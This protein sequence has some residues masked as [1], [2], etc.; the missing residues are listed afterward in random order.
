M[1]NY[2]LFLVLFLIILSGCDQDSPN[3]P[4]STIPVLSEISAPDLIYLLAQSTITI[5][6]KVHDPQGVIDIQ[7]VT[8]DINPDGNSAAARSLKMVDNGSQ[9]DIIPRDGRFTI[10][11]KADTVFTQGG[12]YSLTFQATDQSGNESETVTHQIKAY[13]EDENIPPMVTLNEIPLSI[14]IDDTVYYNISVKV[15]DF[16]GQDD[17]DKVMVHAYS[18]TSAEPVFTGELKDDGVDADETAGDSLYTI[19]VHPLF[20]RLVTGKFS[21]RFQAMDKSGASSYPLVAVVDLVKAAN[22][23]PVIEAVDAPD[24]LQRFPGYIVI[25]TIRVTVS[26]PQGPGDIWKVFFRSYKPDGYEA[27]NSPVNMAD[28][29]DIQTSGDAIAGDGIYSVIIQLPDNT[30]P[31][32]YTFIFEA[33][34]KSNSKSNRIVHPLVVI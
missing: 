10:N 9:N 17:I 5:S 27:G 13:A 19:A 6:I 22:D 26:D 31:G 12:D 4:V 32:T 16:Q 18:P 21:F 14:Y 25:D 34:D 3:D 20:S 8:C 11:V 1:K 33:R 15:T 23:P 24:S 2:L 28:D 29:G 30:N 7:S